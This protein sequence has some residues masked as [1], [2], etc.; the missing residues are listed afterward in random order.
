MHKSKKTS[1][2]RVIG[3][4]V[5]KFPVLKASNAKNVSTWWRHHT[6]E[7]HS[8]LYCSRTHSCSLGKSFPSSTIH[9]ICQCLE[10][11][12]LILTWHAVY[13][14]STHNCYALWRHPMEVFSALLALCAGNS[15]VIDEFPSQ[16]PVTWDFD[17]FFDLCLKKQLNQQSRRWWFETPSRWLW[18]HC[19][20]V[21]WL[22]AVSIWAWINTNTGVLKAT[23]HGAFFP[24][25]SNIIWA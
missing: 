23:H 21:F 17:V 20:G 13:P 6:R 4:C 7:Y 22:C 11:G 12:A 3:F 16:K 5:G 10:C 18:H 2:L 8:V 1:K 24:N 19:S 14:V 15:P 25:H 9:S